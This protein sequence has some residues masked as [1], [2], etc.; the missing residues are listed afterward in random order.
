MACPPEKVLAVIERMCLPAVT[1][2]AAVEPWPSAEPAST[3]SAVRA[4][5]SLP[6]VM[7]TEA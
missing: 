3:W 6:A 4:R 1:Y 7:F 5:M 2:T